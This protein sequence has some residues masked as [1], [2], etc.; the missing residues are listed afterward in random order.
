MTTETPDLEAELH[1]VAA[2][3]A[4]AGATATPP[5]SRARACAA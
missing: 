1:A 2:R 5:T 3:S 4:R